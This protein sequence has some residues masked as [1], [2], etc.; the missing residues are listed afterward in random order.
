MDGIRV[1]GDSDSSDESGTERKSRIIRMT[2][3]T[4]DKEYL[5]SLWCPNS[6]LNC[7]ELSC[8]PAVTLRVITFC[9]IFTFNL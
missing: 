4:G 9:F 2:R 3:T 8:R 5:A 1:S 6:V 7:G